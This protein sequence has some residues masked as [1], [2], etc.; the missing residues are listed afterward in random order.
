MAHVAKSERTG[1]RGLP[2]NVWAVSLTS[3][4]M[5]ISSE[6]VL[7]LA[8]LYLASVLGVRTSL[9]GV[10]EGGAESA[11]SFFKLFS[12]WLSDKLHERKWLAVAGYAVSAL[13]KP[14]F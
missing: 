9:I 3:F 1:L 4:L 10:I 5:D 14:F 6:M 12:G 13:A 2:R 11:A 7:N 8:P